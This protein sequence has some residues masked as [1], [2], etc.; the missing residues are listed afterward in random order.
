MSAQDKLTKYSLSK[1]NYHVTAGTH[2]REAQLKR[3]IKADSIFPV[4]CPDCQLPFK[5]SRVFIKHIKEVHPE[6]LW[7][8]FEDDDEEADDGEGEDDDGDEDNSAA[9]SAATNQPA[10]YVGKGKGRA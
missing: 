7:Q 6:Q 3:A 1:L 8:D 10:S 9:P 2:T 5:D 4:I